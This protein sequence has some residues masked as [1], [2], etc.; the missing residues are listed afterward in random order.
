M[1]AHLIISDR[2]T[3]FKSFTAFIKTNP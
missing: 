3:T 1:A 2:W